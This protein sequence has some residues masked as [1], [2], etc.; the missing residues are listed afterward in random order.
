MIISE[1]RQGPMK[2]TKEISIVESKIE[3][4]RKNNTRLEKMLEEMRNV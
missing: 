4:T 2:K 3:E 1:L